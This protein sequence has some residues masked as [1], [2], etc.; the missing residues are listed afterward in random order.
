MPLAASGSGGHGSH[1]LFAA[2][3]TTE[4]AT[5][6]MATVLWE[7]KRQPF[8]LAIAQCERFAGQ[9]VAGRSVR[10]NYSCQGCMGAWRNNGGVPSNN[11]GPQP[12]HRGS[13]LLLSVFDADRGRKQQFASWQGRKLL[14]CFRPLV[15]PRHGLT[16]N[17][18]THAFPVEPE[19]IGC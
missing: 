9:C 14:A 18:K 1:L 10:L 11:R 19:S 4:Q 5:E 6:E 3:Q 15:L 17:D 8:S 2:G 13:C 12:T 16:L 7:N